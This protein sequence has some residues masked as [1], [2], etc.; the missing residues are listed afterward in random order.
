[1]PP[2]AG[3]E[4]WQRLT[5]HYLPEAPQR[6]IGGASVWQ[7]T[8]DLHLL[9]DLARTPFTVPAMG[10]QPATVMG[11]A[12]AADRIASWLIGEAGLA[13]GT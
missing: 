12:A 2:A 7:M 8:E 13:D 11:S 9:A 6:S 5:V 3:R 4:S 10:G 1:M